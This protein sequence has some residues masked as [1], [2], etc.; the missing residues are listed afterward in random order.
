MKPLPLELLADGSV[1]WKDTEA[2]AIWKGADGSEELGTGASDD[3]ELWE[4]F[5]PRGYA[6]AREEA[7]AV[8]ELVS[9][10]RTTEVARWELSSSEADVCVL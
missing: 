4:D 2:W 3:T 9:D 6:E 1:A 5:V 8:S 7:D 10:E